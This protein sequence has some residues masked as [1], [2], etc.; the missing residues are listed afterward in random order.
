M[1]CQLR[2][3]TH[4]HLQNPQFIIVFLNLKFGTLIFIFL[5]LFFLFQRYQARSLW[6]DW[7]LPLRCPATGGWL[8]PG[9]DIW[10][11]TPQTRLHH[12]P[13]EMQDQSHAGSTAVRTRGRHVLAGSA[14]GGIKWSLH[15]SGRD[16]EQEQ[17][18]SSSSSNNNC[19]R[20]HGYLP[21]NVI[22]RLLLNMFFIL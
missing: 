7:W 11:G 21:A 19:I 18:G 8:F 4:L 9:M 12:L 1:L 16:D 17:W 15:Q 14:T 6:R 10:P 20:F 2:Q 3:A 22:L 13:L 5:M